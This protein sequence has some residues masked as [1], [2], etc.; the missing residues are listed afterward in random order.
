MIN[1]D[2]VLFYILDGECVCASC[3]EPTEKVFD[4]VL[5][6]QRLKGKVVCCCRCMQWH[7]TDE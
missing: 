7:R 4:D 5:T 3:V 6:E 1:T 2:D